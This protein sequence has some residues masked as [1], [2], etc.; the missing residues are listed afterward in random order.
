[1]YLDL[2]PGITQIAKGLYLYEF[3]ARKPV[4]NFDE[5][6][7]DF[8][9]RKFLGKW[10]WSDDCDEEGTLV[11]Y[12]HFKKDGRLY[13]IVYSGIDIMGDG[14]YLLYDA[15]VHIVDENL[16]I[17]PNDYELIRGSFE[18]KDFLQYLFDNEYIT[19]AEYRILSDKGKTKAWT[20][21]LRK[22]QSLVVDA[23]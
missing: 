6:L 5:L 12:K 3:G 19:K 1:M 16:F 14:V 4:P 9:W 11:F 10:V 18:E 17:E 22:M 8:C 7:S 15:K 20:Q 2:K 21:K 23:K 13:Q